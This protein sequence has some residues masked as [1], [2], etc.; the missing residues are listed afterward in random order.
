[1]YRCIVNI[2]LSLIALILYVVLLQ[3]ATAA[4]ICTVILTLG[5]TFILVASIHSTVL[6]RAEK[7][8][9]E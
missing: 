3:T 9:R 6:W 7:Q 8:V 4:V 5:L 2:G 1:M